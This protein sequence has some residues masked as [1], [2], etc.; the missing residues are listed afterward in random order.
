MAGKEVVPTEDWL[1]KL[2][3]VLDAREHLHVTAR[4][5]ARG[6]VDLDE[7]IE[8]GRRA[9]DLG[10]DAVF[11]EAPEGVA[12]LEEIAAALAGRGRRWWPTWSRPAERPC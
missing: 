1:A 6:A 9:A 7:A 5:D 8:R 2:R 10:V 4:T 11:V 3:G 12:E